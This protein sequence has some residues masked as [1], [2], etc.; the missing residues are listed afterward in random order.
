MAKIAVDSK[1]MI[2]LL[3]NDLTQKSEARNAE[4]M[5]QISTEH[6]ERVRFQDYLLGQIDLKAKITEEKIIYEREETKDHF[7]KIEN[8]LNLN[9]Q[10]KEEK[11]DVLINE[12][13]KFHSQLRMA[14]DSATSDFS[15]RINQV[16]ELFA[17]KTS[18][19]EANMN[20]VQTFLSKEC[21]NIGD[22]IRDEVNARFS[23]DVFV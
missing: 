2:K 7:V 17:S 4:L 20:R 1:E 21:D 15:K 16:E 12:N 8:S 9:L 10:R 11:I 13:G 3:V 22:I 14:L 18:Q 6:S 5:R 19:I 23:S